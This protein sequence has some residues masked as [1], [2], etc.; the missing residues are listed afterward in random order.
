MFDER[1]GLYRSTSMQFINSSVLRTLRLSAG[2]G[3]CA[4]MWREAGEEF[5]AGG[6]CAQ[7]GVS[8]GPF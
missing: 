1:T 5:E 6:G 7:L 3:V 4:R 2:R 8:D